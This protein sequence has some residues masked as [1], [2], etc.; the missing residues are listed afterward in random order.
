VAEKESVIRRFAVFWRLTSNYFKTAESTPK[1]GGINKV[2]LFLMLDFLDNDNPLFR[3]AAKNWLIE[4]IPLFYRIIDPLFEVL[5]QN[6]SQWYVTDSKQM[7]Y[8]KIYETRRT[9]ET[10]RKLKS[11]LVTASDL[12]LNYV[13]SMELSDYI[14][15][16]RM[17]FTDEVDPIVT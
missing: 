13:I 8:A 5:L 3:H 2:G 17:H 9:N 16:I 7:F 15:E 6:K 1:L 4:S 12:F 10:F 11:I 14:K